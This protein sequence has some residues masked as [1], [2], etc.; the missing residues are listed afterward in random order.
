MNKLIQKQ[1]EKLRVAK[2][3][4]YDDLKHTYTF[5]QHKEKEFKI[6]SVYIVKLSNSLMI[7]K[8]NEI[9]IS[10]W[11]KGNHPLHQYLKVQVDNKLGSMLFMCGAYYDIDTK[12][13]MNEY[14]N[15]WLPEDE[16][17]IIEEAK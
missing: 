3:D 17:E 16:L 14:W 12:S 7:P 9:L 13:I 1:L 10:N 6:G 15:G 4:S 11:N 5:K 8:N 2:I